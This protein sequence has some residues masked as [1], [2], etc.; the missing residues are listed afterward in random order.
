MKS[1]AEN[2]KNKTALFLGSQTISLFGSSLVQYAI[3]WYIT[4]TT[5]SGVMMTVS[6]L[7]GFLPAFILAPFAG[8]WADRYDRKKQIIYADALVAAST[9]FLAIM[10]MNGYGALWLIFVVWASAQWAQAY[11]PRR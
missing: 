2:W 5:Q 3:T 10:F 11:K 4:L 8:V 7:C 6:I 1:T 9:L